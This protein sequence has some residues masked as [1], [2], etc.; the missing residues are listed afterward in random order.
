MGTLSRKGGALLVGLVCVMTFVPRAAAAQ[1]PPVSTEST[2]SGGGTPS[3]PFSLPAPWIAT[4]VGNPAV[5]GAVVPGN[6]TFAVIGAGTDIGPMTD[7]F[8]FLYQQMTGD[9]QIVA[10]ISGL[11]A[12]D[13]W[14]KAG[15]MI[16]GAL[17]ASAAHASLF[18]TAANGWSFQ[19]RL[20]S[21]GSGFYTGAPIEAG[22]EQSWMRLVRE[23]N[24]FT[25][26][27]SRDGSVWTLIGSETISMPETVY[28]GL[29][30]TSHNA[31]QTATASFGNV[32]VDAPSE[33]NKAPIISMMDPTIDRAYTA[34]ADVSLGAT[35][36]DVDGV[37]TRVDYYSSS[38]LL[39]S[40]TAA[41]F[42]FTWTGVPQGTYTL[43]AVAVDNAGAVGMSD[44]VIL[45]IEGT[46]QKPTKLAFSPPPDHATN[47]SSYA[48]QLRVLGQPQ[49]AAPV[50][51]GNIGKPQVFEGTIVVDISSI[52][53]P[54]PAGT[55]YAVVVSIGQGG[56]TPSAGSPGFTK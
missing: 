51:A 1:T 35:A 27:Q 18:A 49:T 47:V 52:V 7:Q 33:T 19:R 39:G 56:S 15:V 37:V 11:E 23:G 30:V 10:R 42:R 13:A 54:L 55:Y 38:E 17:T 48:V 24:L 25:T 16:R 21:G 14:S 9:A 40:S 22:S 50:A 28:V 32:V 46:P 34:A 53:D 6:G 45:T 31:L 29:A 3:G 20:V 8:Q 2:S 36:T 43:K 4:D 5:A 44:P 26:Y 41:P 12:P